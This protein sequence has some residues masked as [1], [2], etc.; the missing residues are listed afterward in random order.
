MVVM[1]L[2]LGIYKVSF[3]NGLRSTLIFKATGYWSYPL[4]FGAIGYVL[5]VSARLLVNHD[6]YVTIE[7]GVIVVGGTKKI[8]VGSVEGVAITRSIIGKNVIIALSGGSIVRLKGL[9]L[10]RPPVDVASD[11]GKLSGVDVSLPK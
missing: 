7:N 8:P 2:F 11:I 3:E 1:V 5:Y 10:S 6:R 9:Y 4:F